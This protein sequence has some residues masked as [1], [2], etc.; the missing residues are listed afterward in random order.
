MKGKFSIVMVALLAFGLLGASSEDD[1]APYWLDACGDSGVS[2][3]VYDNLS[4]EVSCSSDPWAQGYGG[5][6]IEIWILVQVKV[7]NDDGEQIAEF[8][9][10]LRATGVSPEP[11]SSHP[12]T[13]VG[14]ELDE[15]EV[16]PIDGGEI[17]V[18]GFCNPDTPGI[19]VPVPTDVWVDTDEQLF[20]IKRDG[21]ENWVLVD[22]CA[23]PL[24]GGGACEHDPVETDL[25][26]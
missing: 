6:G 12:T 17:C 10:G 20:H 3:F 11:G 24:Q 26:P 19:P 2:E 7:Y 15:I 25:T 14:Y 22:V 5:T 18:S 8:N 13:W 21:H 4:Y 1:P 9:D 23:R 16:D